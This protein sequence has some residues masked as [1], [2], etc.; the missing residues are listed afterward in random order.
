L[1]FS[2]DIA[3]R[4]SY[5]IIV[6]KLSIDN[7]TET[8]NS[9]FIHNPEKKIN[10]EILKDMYLYFKSIKEWDKMVKIRI[11]RLKIKYYD[12]IKR[13]SRINSK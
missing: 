8:S 1:K 2:I 9:Y 6:N 11:L 13:L 5:D 3:M 12:K 10:D 7:F 4:N